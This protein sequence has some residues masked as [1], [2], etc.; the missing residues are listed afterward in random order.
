MC[1]KFVQKCVIVGIDGMGIEGSTVSIYARESSDDTSNAPP[2]QTQIDNGK[3]WII[4]NKCILGKIYIDNG[5]SGGDW[6]RPDW[7]QVV[8]D[9]RSRKFN[10]ILTWNQDRL[11]RDT[12]QFLWFY[13]KLKER[14]VK[15]FS[16][17]EGEIDMET[18]GGRAKH[19]TLAMA[20]EIF[21]MVTSDK[22]KKTYQYKKSEAIRNNKKVRW[23]R[24]TY[25]PENIESII[26]DIHKKNPTFGYRKIANMLP[27][28][29]GKTDKDGK[30]K[31]FK[32]SHSYVA[33]VLRSV[34]N[35]PNQNEVQVTSETP[36]N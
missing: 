25:L 35:T 21:R 22:V 20:S 19:T 23:G 26:I 4:E 8:K 16:V 6:N 24:A 7:N 15:V 11:A 2:I 30:A 5:Y 31:V 33:S 9:G 34:K 1:G 13:R 17:T 36:A 27:E 18:L 32:V 3:K 29:R 12:E 28:Y 14:G 10:I